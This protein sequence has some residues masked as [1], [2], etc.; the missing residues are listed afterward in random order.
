MISVKDRTFLLDTENTSYLFRIDKYN[1]PEH[2]HYGNRVRIEDAEALA[3]KHFISYGTTVLYDEKDETYCLDHLP[4]EYGTYGRGD[5]KTPSIECEIDGSYTLDFLYDSYEIIEGDMEIDG[6]PSSYSCEKT[7]I[8]HLKEAVKPLRLDLFYAVYPKEDIITRRTVLYNDGEEVIL[9][10]M[11]SCCLDLT[12]KELVSGSLHGAWDKE[13]HLEEREIVPG[14]LVLSS[15]TGFSSAKNNPAFFIRRKDTD[16]DHGKVWGFNLVWT[17]EHHS[18]VSLDEYGI[19]RVETGINHE[20]FSYPLKKG[21]SFMT[22]EAVLSYSDKGLN[23]LS[24]HFHRFIREHITR[25]DWKKKERPVL[26]NSWEGFGFDFNKDGLLKL[27]SSAK[28][29]GMELFVLDD[30]WFGRRNSD[31]RG[32]GDYDPNTR[33]IPGGIKALSKEIHDM[34]ML[35][36]IWVEPEAINTDSALYEAHP[37]YALV[38][39][40]RKPVLGR[41]ELLMDLTRQ[42][43]RDYIVENVSKLIDDNHVD[44]IKWDMNRHHCGI[45]GAYDYEYIRGLYDV[46]ER[47]FTPRPHVLFES[48]ASGGNR[49]D[50]GML[51]YS[52]QIWSSDDTDP[53]ERL[54]IQKGLSCFYPQ[55]AM[56]AHVSASP[57]SQTLRKT[58]LETRFAV[59]ALGCLGYELDLG[60]LTPL[61]KSEIAH[62]VAY[63]KENRALFQYGDFYRF[64]KEEDYECFEVTDGKKAAAVKVRR[65]VH[66]APIFDKL[67]IKGLDPEKIYSITS[68]DHNH[69]IDSFGHLL[70]HALPV[71]VNTDGSLIKAVGRIKGLSAAKQEYTAS[72]SALENGILLDNLFL[73][74]GYNEHLRIPLDYGSDMYLIK[75]K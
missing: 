9:H 62:Q 10:K 57:H 11:M 22:P 25:S 12:E 16:E 6:L 3:Y 67:L 19:C 32:L 14:T 37:E 31:L 15:R 71:K 7:L 64:P 24:S 61:E 36:G 34:G 50:L 42:D 52:P 27:A 68:R 30:G 45:S 51:C 35:F 13:T 8:L 55:S 17:G 23:N 60:R 70:Q 47:I 65:S 2:I 46:L 75:E 28:K 49:F 18:S 48:C 5:F 20:R 53:I 66:A 59:A 1:H 21:T 26:I 69:T 56:G 4:M 40:G 41:H 54:D 43:V 39:E 73:G 29:L 44:Y 33:K 63:Y 58:P 74:T 72:G 38:E